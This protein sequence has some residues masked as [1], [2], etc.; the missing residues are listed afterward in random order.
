[1]NA[2]IWIGL[3]ILLSLITYNTTRFF[4]KEVISTCLRYNI[5]KRNHQKV[6]IPQIG[7]FALALTAIFHLFV[8]YL[9]LY[10]FMEIAI[11]HEMLV[12]IQMMVVCIF[13]YGLLGLFEDIGGKHD[14]IK[15]FHQHWTHFRNGRVSAIGLNRI[16]GVLIA[17]F[18]ASFLAQT[19]FECIVFTA[20]IVGY[21]SVW[22]ILDDNKSGL[23]VKI[24]ILHNIVLLVAFGVQLLWIVSI[25]MIVAIFT[26]LSFETKDK[27]MLGNIGKS[28]LASVSALQMIYLSPST[29]VNISI[30]ILLIIIAII[31]AVYTNR[32]S[33]KSKSQSLASNNRQ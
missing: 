15:G 6:A 17:F 32:M 23:P 2:A 8:V 28:V 31:L 19:L 12:I 13:G 33:I 9:I 5:L 11:E 29:T 25:P 21:V 7:G 14:L 24:S 10:S 18:A 22:N 27:V 20:I 26:F 3:T 16:F 30:S 4:T 1:M